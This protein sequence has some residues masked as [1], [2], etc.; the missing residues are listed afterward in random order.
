MSAVMKTI[1]VPTDYSKEARHAFVYAI[2][3]ARLAKAE[4][5]LLHVFH[6][7]I[8]PSDAVHVEDAIAAFEKEK[9]Y[10]LEEYA[11]EVKADC[12]KN[13]SFLFTTNNNKDAKENSTD[14]LAGF[15]LTK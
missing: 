3:I 7:L 11:A 8:T 9:N 14:Q 2:E 6:Q 12:C 10:R 1:L 13:F 5:V 15:T 4:I